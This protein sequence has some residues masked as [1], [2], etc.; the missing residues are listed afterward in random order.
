MRGTGQA[1]LLWVA[2]ALTLG[3]A[4]LTALKP[5]WIEAF[6]GFDPDG[7]NGAVEW[8]IVLVLAAVVGLVGYVGVRRLRTRGR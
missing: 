6:A 4:I 3:V 2:G 1:V 8:V 7:G 5:G